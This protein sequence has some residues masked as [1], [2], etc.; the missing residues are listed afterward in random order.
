MREQGLKFDNIYRQGIGVEDDYTPS[1][2]TETTWS[3]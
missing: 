3:E 1:P 2:T